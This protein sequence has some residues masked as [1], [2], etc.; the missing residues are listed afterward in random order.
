MVAPI[1]TPAYRD[2]AARDRETRLDAARDPIPSALERG[3]VSRMAWRHG[4]DVD[5][6]LARVTVDTVDAPREFSALLAEAHASLLDPSGCAPLARPSPVGRTVG[7]ALRASP[8]WQALSDASRAHPMIA[9]EAVVGLADIVLDALKRAG[10][11]AATD[12]RNSAAALDAARAALAR[13]RAAA[14]NATTST[15]KRDAL[16]A[17]VDAAAQEERAAAAVAVDEAIAT[18]AGGHID[19]TAESAIAAIADAAAN[20][21]SAV[22]AYSH[23]CGSGTGVGGVASIPDDVVAAITPEVT[24]MLD[25]VGALRSALRNG[26]ASRHVK[27][28]EG[29]IGVSQGGLDRA[30]DLTMVGLASLAGHLGAPMAS[31]TRLAL[32]EATATVLEKGGG[33]ARDGDVVLV[34]DQSG[35]MQGARATWAGALALA[36]LLEARADGRNAALVTF[37]DGVRASIVIDSPASLARAVVELTTASD[38]GTGLAAAMLEASAVL[39][40]MPHGGDP[41]DCLLLTDGAWDVGALEAFPDRARLRGVFIGGSAPEGSRFA[42]TWSVE[43]TEGA[44]A[45]DTAVRIARTVV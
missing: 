35:S 39:G 23:A 30:A 22:H 41:A 26:R 2:S 10:A 6:D 12:T 31:L 33:I 38:G 21:A 20:H 17:T 11:T 16:R 14:K 7:D 3:P 32:V 19:D 9:R 45:K 29:M 44:D 28:R 27:G 4:L 1:R 34:V 25:L 8:S 15:E 40:K 37:D 43:S 18:R 36:V 42:S 13:A 5:A 24:A